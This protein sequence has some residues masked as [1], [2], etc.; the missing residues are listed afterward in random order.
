MS[1]IFVIEV[2][3][4]AVFVSRDVLVVTRPSG[5]DVRVRT[6]NYQISDDMSGAVSESSPGKKLLS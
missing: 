3:H 2:T 5:V 6:E 4:D 1:K